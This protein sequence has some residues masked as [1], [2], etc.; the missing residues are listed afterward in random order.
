MKKQKKL[1]FDPVK[2]NCLICNESILYKNYGKHLDED[3]SNESILIKNENENSNN[4]EPSKQ[5]RNSNF[6]VTF[7][8][9]KPKNLCFLQKIYWKDQSQ[10]LFICTDID[11]HLH[12]GSFSNSIFNSKH[13][14]ILK[15]HLQKCIRRSLIQKS[16][17]TAI[18][19]IAIGA[20][21]ELLRRLLIILAEDSC[22]NINIPI[23]VWLQVANSKGYKLNDEMI[24]TLLAFVEFAAQCEIWDPMFSEENDICH[25][26]LNN[27]V[28]NFF[29]YL[30]QY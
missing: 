29:Y 9:K 11:S 22:L 4:D 19:L 10:D 5:K 23:L 8:N 16:L 18:E 26:N 2:V 3:C 12:Q 25:Q 17:K 15:S 13:I 24:E 20:E 21:Q 7:L 27:A 30:F 28:K 14:P 6:I 1:S